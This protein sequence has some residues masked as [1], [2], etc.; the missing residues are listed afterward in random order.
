MTRDCEIFIKTIEIDCLKK[1]S[2]KM[3]KYVDSGGEN[4]KK[5][6]AVN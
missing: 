6:F 2:F 5:V 1:I 4:A 3:V